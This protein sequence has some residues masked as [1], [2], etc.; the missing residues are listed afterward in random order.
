MRESGL[1]ARMKRRLRRTTDSHHAWP[2]APHLLK[3]D[4]TA[5]HPNQNWTADISDVRTREG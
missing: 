4:F 2:I 3:Q 5:G 1:R